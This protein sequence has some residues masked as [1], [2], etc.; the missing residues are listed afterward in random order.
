MKIILSYIT[1]FIQSISFFLLT[2]SLIL[3]LTIFNESF[4]LDLLENNNYYQELYQ[5]TKEEVS[6]Y[7]EQSGLE[8]N[9]LDNVITKENIENTIISALDNLYTNKEITTDT[10]TITEELT[11]RI[12]DYVKTNNIQV[13]NKNTISTLVSKLVSIYKE[14]ISY[15]N[16][17]EKVRPL[18]N[19]FHQMT[20]VIL[21]L[22]IITSM[23]TY[24]INRY[25][26]KNRNIIVSLFTNGI[27]LV[28]L[29]LYTKYTISINDIT[30]YNESIS[31]VLKEFINSILTHIN[32]VGVISIIL[33]ISLSLVS[34]GFIKALKNNKKVFSGILVILWMLVIFSFSNQNGV[35][36]TSTSNVVTSAIVNV[37]TNVTNKEYTRTEVKKKIEDS[38][39]YIRKAAHFTEYL[40]L[41]ILVLNFLSTYGKINKKMFIIALI[42]CYLYAVSDEVHQIFIP[43]RTAKVLDTL[44]DG[45]GSLIGLIIYTWYS[46]RKKCRNLSNDN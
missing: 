21:I 35:K 9:I 42:C 1:K 24:L 43:G 36:S 11:K 15:N 6:N 40:I 10:T 20:T 38:T 41:G 31:N 27:L 13:E 34:T 25:L 23:V 37:T 2:L 16:T 45:S 7:L 30:F 12:N 29:V 4:T 3:L 26:F 18:F 28:G 17:F 14:E 32:L 5:N 8:E 19:K 39:F 33:G 46:K 22:S 44:I